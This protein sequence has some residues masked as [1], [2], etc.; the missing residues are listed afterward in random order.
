MAANQ[1]NF[2]PNNMFQFTASQPSN[3]AQPSY[4]EALSM[5][6]KRRA[7]RILR[8]NSAGTSPHTIG[9]RKTT[10]VHG[11]AKQRHL[12]DSVRHASEDNSC[13][14]GRSRPIS[15]HPSSYAASNNY[16]P[17]PVP[18]QEMNNTLQMPLE[19]NFTASV[20]GAV[21]PLSFPYPDESLPNEMFSTLDGYHGWAA[22][23][24]FQGFQGSNCFDSAA[25]SIW[26][27][28]SM[29]TTPLTIGP[30]PP[31]Q[32]ANDFRYSTDHSQMFGQ[33]AMPHFNIPQPLSTTAPPTPD[34]LPIQNFPG[35][36]DSKQTSK[37]EPAK[38]ELVGMGLY[39]TPDESPLTDGSLEDYLYLTRLDGGASAARR[40]LGKGLKLEETF[41]PST[42]E[43]D[44]DDDEDDEDDDKEDQD[45]EYMS[46]E[47]AQEIQTEDTAQQGQPNNASTAPPN[48]ANHTFFFEND[49]TSSA[50]KHFAPDLQLGNQ[51][52]MPGGVPYGWF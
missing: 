23:H 46:D 49:E 7:A 4:N 10:A 45:A 42:T 39:D 35:A 41:N 36:L 14:G 13:P 32:L 47:S 12:F 6:L 33:Q 19:A 22:E 44:E 37:E 26:P 24:L 18:Q 3:Q 29:I 30:V 8:T 5:S 11:T 15:W 34:F 52:G 2:Y 9:R 20:N 38:D 17:D 28:Q 25:S 50:A 40:P 51:L 48:L 43:E 21:T 27:Q 16:S 31:A 1:W